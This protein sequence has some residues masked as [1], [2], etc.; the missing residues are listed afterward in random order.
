MQ[1]ISFEEET[2]ARL[3]SEGKSLDDLA[4]YIGISE[5]ELRGLFEL[6]WSPSPEAAFHIEKLR[7][8]PEF[9]DQDFEEFFSEIN[10]VVANKVVIAIMDAMAF[11]VAHMEATEKAADELSE[12]LTKLRDDALTEEQISAQ[13]DGY[14]ALI[15]LLDESE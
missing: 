10:L 2:K 1:K 3:K 12:I 6:S 11:D 15:A 14:K 4:R 13:T 5:E 9:F 7:K 8:I